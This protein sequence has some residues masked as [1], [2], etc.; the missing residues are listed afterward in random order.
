MTLVAVASAAT[1]L[2]AGQAAPS[3]IAAVATATGLTTTSTATDTFER[4]VSGGLGSALTGGAWAV[5][6][7]AAETSVANGTGRV[8]VRTPGSAN[9]VYLPQ[10]VDVV[11]RRAARHRPGRSRPGQRRY[12]SVIGRRIDD[13]SG[14][15]V[16]LRVLS[17]GSV[18]AALLATQGRTST[19]LATKSLA[20]VEYT[21][22][23]RLVVRVQADGT[24]P[25]AL[26][27]KVWPSGQGEPAAWTLSATDSTA[28][29]QRAG[30][31]AASLYVS[32]GATS[33]QTLVL[34]DLSVRGATADAVAPTVSVTPTPATGTPTAATS[35]SLRFTASEAATFACRYDST[36][37]A[38]CTSPSPT[39]ASARIAHRAGARHR[40]GRQR[41]RR[42][43]GHLEGRPH[44][45][46]GVADRRPGVRLAHHGHLGQPA[47]HRLRA[48]P[49]AVPPRLRLVH[50]LH[51]PVR[52]LEAEDR[53][54]HRAGAR[55]RPGG[56]RLADRLPHLDRHRRHPAGRHDGAR[57]HHHVRPGPGLDVDQPVR[58]VRVQA[59]ARQAPSSA[60]LDAGAWTTC[61]S[62]AAFSSLSLAAHTVRIRAVDKAGN[63]DASAAT[64]TWTVV[65]APSA[66][67]SSGGKPG[68][69]N[70]GVPAGTN[71]TVHQGDLTI[72]KDGTK[73]DGVD[74]RGF[75]RIQARNV[76]V[77][78][79]I[80]RGGPTSRLAALVQS[81]EPGVV[82]EDVELAPTNPSVLIDGL[83][84]YGFTAK[85]LDIHHTV[86]GALVW[87]SNTTIQDSWIH[88]NAHYASDPAQGGGPSHDDG[89]QIQGG[90]NLRFTNNVLCCAKNTALMITQDVSKT[91]NLTWNGNWTD[92]GACSINV[93]EKG[94][95]AIQG[96]TIQ[97]N[98]FGRHTGVA[99]CAIVA[100]LTTKVK[101]G[102]NVYDD[103]GQAVVVRKGK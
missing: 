72:T 43:A 13:T 18:T 28:A 68:S 1:A 49:G 66:P 14:Y 81:T 80:I 29:L 2:V 59:P 46:V 102:G 10:P 23:Q 99:G 30:S 22:G 52:R 75:L 57:D 17:D 79:S 58:V 90:N 69:A 101:D 8:A 94:K 56:Q 40:R 87:G 11:R 9:A 85:R 103:N 12:V 32:S 27:A 88:D 15:R 74:V 84:G 41:R 100:P 92:G 64:R 35:S 93:A 63:T 98:R 31:V 38:A 24:A 73:V 37:W 6:G 65:A 62:P 34:D 77:S 60:R 16:R 51:Q 48:R 33:T 76:T 61:T 82:L 5:Q 20:G 21:A 71:L 70:T 42:A 36:A 78:R 89:I 19:T 86:D 50:H 44:R 67:P 39:T 91:S 26:R 4:S 7:P 95:G 3:A 96:L 97:N 25:T 47:V 54:A 45:S 55:L 83:K 53:R